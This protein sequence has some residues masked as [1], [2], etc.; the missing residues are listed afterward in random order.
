MLLALAAS[1]TRLLLCVLA[2]VL[3]LVVLIVRFK[4][5][6]FIGLILA[7]LCVGLCSGMELLSVAKSFQEGVGNTLGFIAVVVGLGTMLGKMLAESGGATVVARTFADWLGPGRLP[8]TMVLVAFIV[9]LPVF[10]GVGM[11][12]LTPVVFSL[13]R[14]TR[15]PLLALGMPMVAGLSVSHCLVPP[16]VGPMVA[17]ERLQA[18]VGRTIL[19]SIIVGLPTALLAG[20]WFSKWAGKKWPE[21]PDAVAGNSITGAA[22]P[23]PASAPGFALTVFTIAL[24]VV[25]MLLDT[26]ARLTLP[27]ESSVRVW[28]G[29]AGS[30]LVSMT[31]A[32][33][34]SFWSFGSARGF[35]R[36]QI[37][38]FAED[39][40]GPAASIMLVVGAGGGFSKVLEKAGAAEAIAR[41]VG[42]LDLS[43]LVLG[44]LVAALIRLAVG[45][46][47]VTITLT[48]AMLAPVALAAPGLNRELLVLAIG[49]G[50]M[51]ASHVND[52]GFWFVKE[53]LGLTVPQTLKTWT[54]LETV[55]S[56]VALLFTLLLGAV[57][58]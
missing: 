28:A 2:A 58:S 54:V 57:L 1:D 53:S 18:D 24:P 38:K 29:F 7:S 42:G 16:H 4:L 52:G 37:L 56:V 20:V 11:L 14:A 30:A 50:S 40:V 17:I 27:P 43:P 21:P 47:T 9:G 45:S 36:G 25:L 49:A 15:S 48:A 44:W 10:F 41:V 33:L 3:G 51:I 39:C 35:N 23:A 26:L 22:G 46:A 19:Y 12:L 8:V 5:H 34:F 32:L 55:V 13:A 31:V 6:A